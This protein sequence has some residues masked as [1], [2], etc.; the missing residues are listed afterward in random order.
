MMV[1]CC[2]LASGHKL[3]AETIFDKNTNSVTMRLAAPNEL[4]AAYFHHALTMIAN[5]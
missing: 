1:I 3:I 5:L 4:F 2:L